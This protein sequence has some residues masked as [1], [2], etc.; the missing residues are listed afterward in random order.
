MHVTVEV[1]GLYAQP[2]SYGEH[3]PADVL[4]PA[5]ATGSDKATDLDI[6]I[7]DPTNKTALGRWSNRKPLVAAA[8]W[9]TVKLGTHTRALEEAGDQG[10]SFTKGPCL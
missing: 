4:V 5:S 7:T 8:V 3:T 2:T 6:T 9:H 1:Q 10:L